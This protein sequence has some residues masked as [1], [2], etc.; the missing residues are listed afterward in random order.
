MYSTKTKLTFH[1][2]SM[3]R[4]KQTSEYQN[5]LHT[6]RKYVKTKK[7]HSQF[8]KINCFTRKKK[9]TKSN[10][11]IFLIYGFLLLNLRNDF[12]F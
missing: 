6:S 9:L 11:Y 5:F 8:R 10:L 12:R 7:R 4:V 1:G 3:Y 2:Y